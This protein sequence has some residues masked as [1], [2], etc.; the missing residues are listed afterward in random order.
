MPAAVLVHGLLLRKTRHVHLHS[1]STIA[2]T[3]VAY[4]RRDGQT[5]LAQWLIKY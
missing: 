2:G 5:E 4:P 3:H 1:G